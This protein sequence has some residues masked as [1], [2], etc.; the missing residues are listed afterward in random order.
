MPIV[1]KAA[2]EEPLIKR[3]Q[4]G[5][6]GNS[7]QLVQAIVI[8][9]DLCIKQGLAGPPGSAAGPFIAGKPMLLQ[10]ALLNFYRIEA[11]K[12]KVQTAL[13][14]AAQ[15]KDILSRIKEITTEIKQIR[16]EVTKSISDQTKILRQ[17]SRLSNE[18]TLENKRKIVELKI[19]ANNLKAKQLDELA[20]LQAKKDEILQAAKPKIG[21][22]K[23][24]LKGLLIR[25]TIPPAQDTKIKSLAALPKQIKD[26]IVNLKDKKKSITDEIKTSV[27]SINTSSKSFKSIKAGLTPADASIIK[28]KLNTAIKSTNINTTVESFKIIM[29]IVNKYPDDKISLAAKNNCRNAINKII[30]SKITIQNKK[31]EI[32]DSILPKLK[33]YKTQ[34]LETFKPNFAPGPSKLQESLQDR[35]QI[36]NILDQLK[37]ASRE[38]NS[39]LRAVAQTK[40]EYSRILTAIRKKR[41]NYFTNEGLVSILNNKTLNLGDKYKTIKSTKEAKVFMTVLLIDLLAQNKILSEKRDLIKNKYLKEYKELLIKKKLNPKEILFNQF[42]RIG[43]LGYWT[44]GV[45]GVGAIA[46]VV[47]PG[48]VTLPVTFKSTAN[49]AAFIQSLSRTFQAHLKT[50]TGLITFPT[51]PS[52]TVLPW[53]TYS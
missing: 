26:L 47:F 38:Y 29:G 45:W 46:N 1:W 2:F 34:L 16:S 5:Q 49:Q 40:K 11:T 14:Y 31:Q 27:K 13:L 17:I 42:L 18:K 4:S 30:E 53:S 10:Q 21:D 24:Q 44:G 20:R 12:Q 8:Q 35:K 48:T 41:T 32:K 9:Y 43:L 36:K 39:N 6:I 23:R 37:S 3:I 33:E 7:K 15:I 19:K 51:A 52:P 28:S 50:V 22:I 25:I